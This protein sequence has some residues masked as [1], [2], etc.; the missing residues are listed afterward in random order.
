MS[1]WKQRLGGAA[2]AQRRLGSRRRPGRE[3]LAREALSRKAMDRK[4]AVRQ[5]SKRK[6]TDLRISRRRGSWRQF[7][8]FETS[9]VASSVKKESWSEPSTSLFFYKEAGTSQQQKGWVQCSLGW[10]WQWKKP[11]S[12]T[13]RGCRSGS[14][15]SE[16]FGSE[17]LVR[18]S[19]ALGGLGGLEGAGIRVAELK[20]TRLGSIVLG[21]NRL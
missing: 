18:L 21:W 17:A 2:W 1:I 10:Q 5:L 6:V 13:T 11:C 4:Q 3:A 7:K 12:I 15:G 20:G 19:T 14:S 16:A 8:W 9:A